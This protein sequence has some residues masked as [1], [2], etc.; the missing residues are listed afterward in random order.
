MPRASRNLG[1]HHAAGGAAEII[2]DDLDISKSS[3][4]RFLD[5]VILSALALEM[6]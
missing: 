1:G 5:Q 4:P 2:V 3:P 6:F